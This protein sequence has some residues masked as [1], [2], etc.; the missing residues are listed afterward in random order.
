MSSKTVGAALRSCLIPYADGE[1][2][3]FCKVNRRWVACFVWPFYLA[4][5]VFECF[6]SIRNQFMLNFGELKWH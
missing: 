3:F 4:G 5:L 2:L 6:M 1:A